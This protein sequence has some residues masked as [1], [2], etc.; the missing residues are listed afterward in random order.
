M[1]FRQLLQEDDSIPSHEV[2]L[3][4]KAGQAVGDSG[5]VQEWTREGGSN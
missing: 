2:P 4:T 3:K 1:N 5:G